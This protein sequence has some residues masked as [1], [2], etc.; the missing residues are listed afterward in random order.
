MKIPFL[1][2]KKKLPKDPADN[3]MKIRIAAISFIGAILAFLIIFLYKDFYQTLV[4][5]RIVVVLK[6]EV[7]LEN[8][9]LVLFRKVFEKHSF[10][11]SPSLPENIPDPFKSAK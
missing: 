8:I 3:L 6:Q 1:T 11:T 5:A 2:K 4:Q 9:D 7:S 10:K